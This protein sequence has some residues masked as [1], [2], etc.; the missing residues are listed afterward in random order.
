MKNL[1]VLPVV[2]FGLLLGTQSINAQELSS[3]ETVEV[4]A[5][6]KY[7]ELAVENLPQPVLDA[8]AKDFAGAT[9][10]KAAAKEDASEFKLELTK[11]DGETVEVHCD[12]EGNWVA[13]D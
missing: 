3:D 9:I 7:I 8:V 4:T 10:S 13:K 2:A 11:E 1:F 12:A 6:E 5:Q